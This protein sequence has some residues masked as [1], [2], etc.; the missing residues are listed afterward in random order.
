M[1]HGTRSH[2]ESL[3]DRVGEVLARIG[4]RLAPNKT[5]ISP[6]D[7]GVDF[8]GFR[9]RRHRRYGSERTLIYTYP[10]PR[11]IAAIEW[12][13]KTATTRITHHSADRLFSQLGRQ[14]R[15]WARYFRHSSASGAY[16]DVQHFLWWRVWHWLRNKH[17]RMG[18]RWIVQRYYDGWCPEHDGVRL[19]QPATMTIKRYRYRGASIPSPWGEPLL[20]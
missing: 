3:W 12:K 15:G 18:K 8:L 11:S 9:I 4:L 14:V 5:R 16:H 1:V 2:A 7:E 13:V 6:I 20:A 19:F 17:P 10:S